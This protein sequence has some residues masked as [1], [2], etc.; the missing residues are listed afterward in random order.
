[1]Q[2]YLAIDIG[3][4]SGRHVLGW[5]EG[6]KMQLEEVHRFDNGMV[7]KNGTL[8]WDTQALFHEILS[9]MKKCK[10]LGKIPVSVGIDTWGVDFVLLD[11]AGNLLGDAVGYRD[12]RNIG[13]DR[14]V[15]ACMPEAELYARTGIQK[16]VFNTIYQLMAVKKAHPEYLEQAHRL[17]MMPDYLHYKLCGV[18]ANE[19]TEA[20]TGGMVNAEAKA[21][22]PAILDACGY[23]RKIFGPLQMPGTLLGPLTPEVEKAVGYSCAVVL[24][25]SHDTASAVLAVP[26]LEPDT[27]YI[28]SGT[29]SLMGIERETPDT[30]DTSFRH[31]FTNEGGYASR[32]RY[33]KNIM[34][35]WMVQCLRKELDKRYS[36]AELCD[37]AA[38]AKIASIVDCQDDRFLAPASMM[39][40]VK[41]F[42][43]ETNQQ[44]PAT[45]AEYAA[46]IYNS[47]A[48]CYRATVED[49]QQLTGK[50]FDAIHVVG[51]G[52]NASY[53][54]QLTANITGKE[55]TAGPTEATA[56]GNLLAQMIAKAELPD[57][58]AARACVRDSF[59]VQAYSPK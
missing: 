17:L 30:S 3:A 22:D 2:Y 37:M 28:S 32:Y 51:G 24:P 21:W 4:S 50:V 35:L 20:S 16:Q 25:G 9:G 27:L 5:L 12:A 8:C 38:E 13:M 56:I 49:L 46:V 41:A 11:A 18:M 31:N 47:L 54:N 45:P 26:S 14:E 40:A 7:D 44:A 23:P 19:Y 34:G 55:V 15:Y 29:W 58:G 1:M 52:S 48:H 57:V 43:V 6:G 42:C 59:A 36:Y 10:D 33:L 39:D 53:L